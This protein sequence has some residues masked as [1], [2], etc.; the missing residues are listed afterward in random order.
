MLY[1]LNLRVT[2]FQAENSVSIETHTVTE[3]ATEG[4]SDP[5]PAPPA[6]PTVEEEEEE[7]VEEECVSALQLIG[8][9]CFYSESTGLQVH[10]GMNGEKFRIKSLHKLID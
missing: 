7:E 8:G 3:A 5:G 10:C 9:Q 6:P 4:P 2:L 1:L